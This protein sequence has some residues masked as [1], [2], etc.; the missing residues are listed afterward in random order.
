M[1]QGIVGGLGPVL[2]VEGPEVALSPKGTSRLRTMGRVRKRSTGMTLNRQGEG[3]TQRLLSRSSLC[4]V[5]K[6]KLT[7][8]PFGCLSAHYS[9]F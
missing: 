8:C 3:P 1:A 5:M 7:M 2:G 4:V 6:A 9:L